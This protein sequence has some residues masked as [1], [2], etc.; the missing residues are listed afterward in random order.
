[1][2]D[3]E[4]QNEKLKSE[5]QTILQKQALISKADNVIKNLEYSYEIKFE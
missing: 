2:Q 4:D 3:L 1:M 5:A